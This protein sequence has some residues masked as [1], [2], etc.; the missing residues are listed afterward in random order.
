MYILGHEYIYHTFCVSST[1]M[2][3]VCVCVHCVCIV[4]NMYK[5]HDFQN[6][7]NV[8]IWIYVYI[9]FYDVYE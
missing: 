4:I 1:C 9:I 3:G 8:W 6:D 5:R 2:F 7:E